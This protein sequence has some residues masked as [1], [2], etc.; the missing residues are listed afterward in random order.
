MEK[1]RERKKG[2]LV[3][4]EGDSNGIEGTTNWKGER[5]WI[6]DGT[7]WID[8]KDLPYNIIEKLHLF[9]LFV[10]RRFL[11]IEFRS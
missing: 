8:P 4:K 6:S 7:R 11:W 2:V 10:G 3:V 1:R 9:N 5:V